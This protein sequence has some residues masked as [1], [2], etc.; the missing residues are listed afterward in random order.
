M[1]ETAYETV[2]YR[3]VD[4]VARISL[5]RPDRLHAMNRTM[6][7]ELTEAFRRAGREARA[8]LLTSER[9]ADPAVKPSFCAGQDLG[10][11]REEDLETILDEEYA[12]MLRALIDAPIP[13]V[14]AII[15]P[16]AGAGLHLALSADVIFGA[17]SA[18]FTAP[19]SR[20]GLMP[21]A[22]GSYWLPRLA[23]PQRAAGMAF[24]GEP[25]SAEQAERWGLIWRAL[26][27]DELEAAAERA[28][29]KIA[30]GPT[31]ALRATK[32]AFRASLSNGL[33]AQLALE[34][35][36]QGEAGRSRD[37]MEGVAAFLEKRKPR[38]EGR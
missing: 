21:A 38:F 26:P 11:I 37:Y 25:V 27:D 31:V 15:G 6:R 35:K 20:I 28:A 33:E 8:I 14:A 17:R 4:A 29:A 30:S 19:F 32:A 34:T 24:L 12:P 18:S 13:S 7:L 2:R 5:N 23:G 1:T 36:L 9:S 10:A 22:A 3:M 16:A